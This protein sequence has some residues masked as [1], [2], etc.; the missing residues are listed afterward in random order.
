MNSKSRPICNSVVV[1]GSL[2]FNTYLHPTQHRRNLR[3]VDFLPLHC[4]FVERYVQR[5]GD[6]Q[7]F[8]VE[9]PTLDVLVAWKENDTKTMF[10]VHTE[11]L[12]RRLSR[13]HLKT[14]LRVA[15]SAH[16]E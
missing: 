6:V 14:T 11:S 10:E 5:L 15:Y 13:E 1:F 3:P 2:Q 9:R 4:N 12:S 8:Y 16:T 7:Q